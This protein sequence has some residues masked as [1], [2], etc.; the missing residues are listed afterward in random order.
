MTKDMSLAA[1]AAHWDMSHAIHES[2]SSSIACKVCKKGSGDSALLLGAHY[3]YF[4]GQTNPEHS[5]HFRIMKK[6]RLSWLPVD[7]K[8][9]DAPE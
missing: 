8:I 6:H 2:D 4:T 9:Q 1:Y 5:E 3:G 7:V